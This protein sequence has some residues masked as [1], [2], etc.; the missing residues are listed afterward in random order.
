MK[1]TAEMMKYAIYNV[2]NVDLR[3]SYNYEIAANE[4]NDNAQSYGFLEYEISARHTISGVPFA[5]RF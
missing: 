1:V 2:L 5:V 3:D 4:A